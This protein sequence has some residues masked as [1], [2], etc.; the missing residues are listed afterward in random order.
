MAKKP[1]ELDGLARMVQKGFDNVDKQFA[2]L[3]YEMKERFD[4]LERILLED[5]QQ[6]I[7]RLEDQVK[8]LQSDYRQLLGLKNK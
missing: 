3:K 4:D 1:V 5:H 6:R 2:D 8:E 7:E